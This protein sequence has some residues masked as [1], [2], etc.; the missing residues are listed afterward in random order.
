M[1]NA[2]IDGIKAAGGQAEDFGVLSTPQLHYLV[3]CKNTKGGYGEPTE[4]GYFAKIS[5]AFAQF[6]G[7]V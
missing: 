5:K 6:R 3:V 7:Q 2:V 4:S 1:S